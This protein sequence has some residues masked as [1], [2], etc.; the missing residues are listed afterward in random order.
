MRVLQ[1]PLCT[2][3]PQVVEHA[4]AMFE[5]LSDP[6]IYEFEGEPP[7]TMERLA[8]GYRRK[9]G[10][11]SPSGSEKWLN[12]VIRLPDGALAG[13]VQATVLPSGTSYIGYELAS[14]YWRQGLGAAAVGAVVEELASS[15][16]VHTIVAVLKAANERSMGLLHHLGFEPATTAQAASFV[17]EPDEVVM[18]KAAPSVGPASPRA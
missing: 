17:P 12:W 8:Q 11:A 4:D 2:L 6:A 5:V 9:E 10:R 14:R 16:A 13:Y 7:A 15:Y 18:L 3:E 1:T